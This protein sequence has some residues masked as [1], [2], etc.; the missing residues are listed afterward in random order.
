MLAIYEIETETG[1]ILESTQKKK[2]ISIF[3]SLWENLIFNCIVEGQSKIRTKWILFL[4]NNN[5]F[6]GFKAGGF[7]TVDCTTFTAL[8]GIILTYLIILL[9]WK[10]PLEIDHC[11]VISNTLSTIDY[12]N[13][14]R[15]DKFIE[16]LD[17][18]ADKIFASRKTK[19]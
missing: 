9:Q 1:I 19:A 5:F 17:A 12:A 10:D 11:E 15:H 6:L 8:G 4:T 18:M 13:L 7:F 3:Y 14:Q 16:K 2:H